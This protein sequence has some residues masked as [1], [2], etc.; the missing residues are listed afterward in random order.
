MEGGSSC[1]NNF[2]VGAI[3]GAKKGV[4]HVVLSA[5]VGVS[6]ID[7]AAVGG[8]SD[9]SRLLGCLYQQVV[10]RDSCV[11]CLFIGTIYMFISQRF[12]NQKRDIESLIHNKHIHITKVI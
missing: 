10:G 9:S 7:D 4:N 5:P 8:E 1:V 11:I 6:L 3:I 12:L 2:V